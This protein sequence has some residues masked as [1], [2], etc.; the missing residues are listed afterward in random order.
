MSRST[1]VLVALFFGCA[2]P[3][4][5]ET[6]AMLSRIGDLEERLSRL[7]SASPPDQSDVTALSDEVGAL[8]ESLETLSEAVDVA[9][10]RLTLLE[11]APVQNWLHSHG[12]T[13]SVQFHPETGEVLFVGEAEHGLD[14]FDGGGGFW[15]CSL[16]ASGTA[17]VL[18]FL[19]RE[20]TL[21]AGDDP[22][23][24]PPGLAGLYVDPAHYSVLRLDLLA[25]ARVR[26]NTTSGET[27]PDS[28]YRDIDPSGVAVFLY[29]AVDGSLNIAVMGAAVEAQLGAGEGLGDGTADRDNGLRL[30]LAL[31]ATLDL[32]EEKISVLRSL[33]ESSLAYPTTHP[34]GF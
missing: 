6:A 15:W 31:R 9:D 8:S 27:S 23:L 11:E 28:D 2:E 5:E 4:G 32:P 7:E 16:G 14:W 20:G 17:P 30:D 34:S 10:A 21:E 12:G 13:R 26:V 1:L 25:G 33:S 29:Q 18:S 19:L 3:P 22:E 24:L